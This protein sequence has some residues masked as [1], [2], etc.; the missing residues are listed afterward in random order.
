MI[1]SKSFLF[2]FFYFF[3]N[4]LLFFRFDLQLEDWGIDT[5]QLKEPAIMW[6]IKGWTEEWEKERHKK[7]DAVSKAVFVNQYKDIVF[8][9][10]TILFTLSKM[11]YNG[12]KVGTEVGLFLESVT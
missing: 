4:N 3:T 6:R 7:N 9:M 12:Y 5:A 8:D 11:K 2:L 1:W 10:I